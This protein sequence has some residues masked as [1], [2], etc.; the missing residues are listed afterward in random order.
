[1]AGVGGTGIMSAFSYLISDSKNK[2]FKEPEILAE[3]ITRIIPDVNKKQAT[4]AGWGLH[5]GTG[6]LFTAIYNQIWQK[7]TIKPSV[8]SG[9]ILGAVS[10][11]VGIAVWR[12]TIALHPKPPIK[13]YKSY[14]KHLLLAHIIFGIGAAESYKQSIKVTDDHEKI[15]YQ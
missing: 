15:H 10:G 5:L 4:I 2:N 13:D 9:A 11:V 6:M 3:L 7:T 1:M 14:Y 12:A 8:K